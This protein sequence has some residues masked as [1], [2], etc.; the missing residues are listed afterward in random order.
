MADFGLYGGGASGGSAYE[1]YVEVATARGDPVLTKAQWADSLVG[2]AG[3]DFDLDALPW[4]AG[5]TY[6]PRA[7]VTEGGSS[8][9]ALRATTGERPSDS[10]TAWGL[11]VAGIDA[12]LYDDLLSAAQAEATAAAASASLA[13][14]KATSATASA[15]AASASAVS[16]AASASAAATDAAIYASTSAGLADTAVD[17]QFAVIVSDEIV[18]YRHDAGPVATEV[19]RYPTAELV[20]T[21]IADA[22]NP[23]A[24]TAAQ[25]GLD[26][27]DNT[28]DA[29]KPVSA[30]QQ[31]ALD[32]KATRLIV[33][34]FAAA[35]A[36]VIGVSGAIIEARD[37]GGDMAPDAR[38]WV[39]PAF[40][41]WRS[42][43]VR[44]DGQ[45][46]GAAGE[47]MPVYVI[48]RIDAWTAAAVN[49]DGDFC[50]VDVN[51]PA[52]A[53]DE[54]EVQLAGGQVT[55]RTVPQAF[56]RRSGSAHVPLTCGPAAVEILAGGDGDNEAVIRRGD[57]VT[58]VKW[59]S[60]PLSDG[61]TMHL[62]LMV[63]QSLAVGYTNSAIDE[64]LPA[65]RDFVAENA[66]QFAAGDGVQRGPRPGQALPTY[67]SKDVV[68]DAAQL[69]RLEPLRGATFA[70]NPLFGQ[71]ACETA[72]FALLGHHLDHRDHVLAAAIGTGST[73]IAD[74]AAG[75]EHYQSCTAV[76]TAAADHAA[77]RNRSLQVWLLWSQGE[78]DNTD[79]TVQATYEAA[80]IAIR[81]GLAAHA[82][83]EGATFGGAVIQQCVQRPG[84][85]TGMAA[86]A[87][88]HL[89]AT[90]EAAGVT[91]VPMRPGHSDSAHL[92][93]DAYLPLGA[94]LATEIARAIDGA[95]VQLPVHVAAGDA[96]LT[97]STQIDCTVSGLTGALAVD[98]A[99]MAADPNGTWGA[100]VYD[101]AGVS[102]AIAS[103]Q[104]VGDDVLRITLASALTIGSPAPR[105]EFGLAGP[106]DMSASNFARVNLRD[107]SGWRCPA[108]GQ[109]VSG[110]M[111]H[112][113]V[114]ITA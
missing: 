3:A 19:A 113:R 54:I 42:I 99:T 37:A 85:V 58:A 80:W 93:P 82:V 13:S 90:G 60:P 91:P 101:S 77:A 65:W 56:L 71:T 62:L 18:R 103:V 21:H 20:T 110:W 94:A 55:G 59:R 2:P 96:V 36:L 74:F 7:G 38:S 51:R 105:V 61:E 68:V 5:V 109:V 104:I 41:A 89:M 47:A 108:T 32:R 88:A 64:R 73:P 43:D 4:Q 11:L 15:S 29:D 45:I 50:A 84:S 92:Y 9:L 26:Q 63:G 102:A 69:E 97:T 48:P 8:W 10:P 83:S 1:V 33:P 49:G 31:A 76:I 23:H 40:G 39:V 114:E 79:G 100:R 106:A 86:L 53:V 17:D 52:A 87:H 66:W 67:G 30:P 46:V 81:D 24:T 16:A 35:T 12:E 75:T 95:G 70:G 25:V 111:I 44:A 28:A 72:A 57:D 27:V 34:A 6:A 107:D 78:Q 14:T 22:A 112:H 98:T